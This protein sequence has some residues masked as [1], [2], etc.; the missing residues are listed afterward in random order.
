MKTISIRELHN[1]TGEVVRS[2]S[3]FGG[4]RVTDN[5]RVIARI[6]PM[7]ETDETPYFARR[8]PSDAFTRLDRSWK[9]SRGADSTAAISE[10]REDRC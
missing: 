8:K 2:A 10:D 3:R 4:I 9:T 7:A 1:Q 5:G 6:I